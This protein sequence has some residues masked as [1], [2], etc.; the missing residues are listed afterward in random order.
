MINYKVYLVSGGYK[1]TGMEAI[2]GLR[3]LASSVRPVPKQAGGDWA[4]HFLV[5][6]FFRRREGAHG[7]I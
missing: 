6:F 4:S 2:E 5:H 1:Q 7:I 3:F